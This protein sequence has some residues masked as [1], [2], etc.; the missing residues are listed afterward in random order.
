MT[1]TR[2]MN[3]RE[4]SVTYPKRLFWTIHCDKFFQSIAAK[5]EFTAISTFNRCCYAIE[6]ICN[7]FINFAGCHQP[8]K[9]LILSLISILTSSLQLHEQ[10]TQQLSNSTLHCKHPKLLWAA[11]NKSSQF[12]ES[13]MSDR[14]DNKPK[15]SKMKALK[16]LHYWLCWRL[17]TDC[18]LLHTFFFV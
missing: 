6:Q 1:T 18:L 3:K 5:L 10:T 17:Q 11:V 15:Y 2:L 9:A 12:F 8:S 7:V 16:S 14:R 13:R 4:N